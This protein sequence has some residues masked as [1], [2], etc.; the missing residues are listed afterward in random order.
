MRFPLQPP[1]VE[2]SLR[3]AVYSAFSGLQR[4]YSGLGML[5]YQLPCGYL[6]CV[7]RAPGSTMEIGGFGP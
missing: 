4:V 2:S 6:P 5:W 7:P 1:L 3:S